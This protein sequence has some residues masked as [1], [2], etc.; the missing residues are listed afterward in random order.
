MNNLWFLLSKTSSKSTIAELKR[1]VPVLDARDARH[2][3]GN[4]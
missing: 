2:H 1:L 4:D 3:Y